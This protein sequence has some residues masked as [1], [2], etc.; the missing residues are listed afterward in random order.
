MKIIHII[1]PFSPINPSSKPKAVLVE[2]DNGFQYVRDH[3]KSPVD[4]LGYANLWNHNIALLVD[5][6]SVL[7]G[8]LPYNHSL[9]DM[10]QPIV[11]GDMFLV[12]DD[13]TNFVGLE[14]EFITQ[15]LAKY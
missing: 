4:V 7:K 1:A 3:F 14:N 8:Y 9:P 2:I 15:F 13:G 12:G 6:E 11:F 5:D 10:V